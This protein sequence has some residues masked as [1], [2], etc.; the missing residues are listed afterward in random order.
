VNPT[1]RLAAFDHA[2]GAHVDAAV[3]ELASDALRAGDIVAIPTDT[4]YGLAAAVDHP[5]AVTRLYEVKGRPIEKAIPVLLSDFSQVPRVASGLSSMARTLASAF[6]PGAL[7]LVLA[8]RPHLPL[9]LT[10][11]AEDGLRTVA[12]RVPD[13]P[14]TTAIIAAAGGAL[15]VTSANRSGEKP[16]LE[17]LEAAAL[18]GWP[19]VLVIDGGRVPGGIPSTVV[20]TTGPQPAILREGAIPATAILSALRNWE[21][22][23]ADTEGVQDRVVLG[24]VRGSAA[25]DTRS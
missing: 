8:A 1:S 25:P 24:P 16:A 20:L 2:S 12:V 6:W 23:A 21:E 10:S 9:A 19:P 7:T 17:A 22:L 18:H 11:V 5:E 4:V 14:L 13:H 15:A 3:V